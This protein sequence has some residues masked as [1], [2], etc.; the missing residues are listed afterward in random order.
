MSDYI[1]DLLRDLSNVIEKKYFYIKEILRL[2]QKQKRLIRLEKINA[3]LKQIQLKEEYI[4]LIDV[5]DME[6]NNKE[7]ELCKK[8]G[9]QHLDE[10]SE[11]KYPKLKTI[12]II[13]DNII[14]TLRKIKIIDDENIVDMTENIHEVK[15]KIKDIR[16]SK[17]ISNAY[18]SYKHQVTSIFFDRKK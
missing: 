16:Q 4:K 2:T 15:N 17:K 13:K 7:Y 5:L 12:N 14:N 9:L 11:E 8:L 18:T 1:N 3:L 10:I 6:F